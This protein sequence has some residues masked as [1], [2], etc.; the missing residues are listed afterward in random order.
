MGSD[1]NYKRKNSEF[2]EKPKEKEQK[3]ETTHTDGLWRVDC[4]SE[5]GWLQKRARL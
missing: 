2:R 5:N 4:T 3:G 1:S